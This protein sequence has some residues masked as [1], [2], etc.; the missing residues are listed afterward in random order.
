M[1]R[2]RLPVPTVAA[3]AAALLAAPAAA[4]DTRA[5]I[6]VATPE[7]TLLE[8]PL[9]GAARS[10]RTVGG[11]T[12][13]LPQDTALGQLVAATAFF[14]LPLGITQNPSLGAFV[15][16][17]GGRSGGTSGYWAFFVNNRLSSVG[18][19]GYTLRR[20]DEVVW[21][22]DP[23]FAKP[24]P[25]FLDLDLVRV[26]RTEITFRVTRVAATATG[27]R[28]GPAVGASVQVNSQVFAVGRRGVV[29]VAL[30]GRGAYVARATQ[31]GTIAS[32]TLVTVR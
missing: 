27:Y 5:S 28:A 16:T 22:L 29:R 4:A 32:E 15:S 30:R 25:N 21:I 10:Y 26:R 9:V 17:I 31:R 23:D 20:N 18:A 8:A 14:G 7:R 11:G 1:S 2:T 19:G 13:P 6:R 12:L 24:G 3:I